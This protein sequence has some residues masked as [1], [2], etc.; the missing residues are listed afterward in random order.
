MNAAQIDRIENNV[1]LA[2]SAVFAG[3]VAYAFYILLS[4][5]LAGL[6][7]GALVA[8]GAV[9]AYL[10]CKAALQSFGSARPRFAVPIFDVRDIET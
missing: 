4:S 2:A 6:E 1:Q 9:V 7:V 10:L 8:L 5:A 3:A